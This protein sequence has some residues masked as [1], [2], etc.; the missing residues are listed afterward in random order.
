[1]APASDDIR[2]AAGTDQSGNRC[3]RLLAGLTTSA[4]NS[5]FR[6]ASGRSTPPYACIWAVIYRRRRRETLPTPLTRPGSQPAPLPP[7]LAGHLGDEA[8]LGD[9]VV[10]RHVVALD[11]AGEAA[12]RGEGELV[13]GDVS[14]RLVDA[15]LQLVLVLE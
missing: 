1:M 4:G 10:E 9:L 6:G 13:E 14:R 2:T 7:H 5:I 3:L 8:E 15:A 12:L 11:R